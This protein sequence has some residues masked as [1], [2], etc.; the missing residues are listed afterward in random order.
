MDSWYRRRIRLVGGCD[1]VVVIGDRRQILIDTEKNEDDTGV[2]CLDDILPSWML[3][4]EPSSESLFGVLSVVLTM[5][6]LTRQ[7]N[8]PG[9]STF[10]K[11]SFHCVDKLERYTCCLF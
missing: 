5:T 6:T 7:A 11:L 1:D 3:K 8:L 2:T 10:Q 9:K 4:F